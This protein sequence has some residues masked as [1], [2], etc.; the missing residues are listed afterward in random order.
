MSIERSVW[1]ITHSPRIDGKHDAP[2]QL[3]NVNATLVTEDLFNSKSR[4]T[5]KLD[6][7]EAK[8]KTERNAHFVGTVTVTLVRF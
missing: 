4:K 7:E 8:T 2:R 6:I 3:L 5:P 1:E